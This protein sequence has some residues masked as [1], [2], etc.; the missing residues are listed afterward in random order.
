M[1]FDDITG[2]A[3]GTAPAGETY[4]ALINKRALASEL[5]KYER[6]K[7]KRKNVDSNCLS[8]VYG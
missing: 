2:Q 4:Q 1:E 6:E 3:I 8:E 7:G 5:G